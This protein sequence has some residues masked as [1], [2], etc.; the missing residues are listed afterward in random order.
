MIPL[1]ARETLLTVEVEGIDPAGDGAAYATVDGRRVRIDYAIA[2]ERVEVR[3]PA[4]RGG[5]IVGELARVLRPSPHRV[6]PGCPYFGP[7][8]GCTWQHI[9][10]HEQLRLKEQMLQALLHQSLGRA[11]PPVRPTRT[12]NGARSSGLA[13]AAD[14]QPPTANREP[15]PVGPDL[16]APWAFRNKVHFVLAPASRLGGLV[17]GHYHRRSQSVV[18]VDACPVHAGEGNRVAFAVRD[19][20]VRARVEGAP[21]D[22]RRGARARI[23][24]GAR[25]ACRRVARHIVVRATDTPRET[26]ATL[27]V[28]R[29]ERSLRP[30]V[31]AI[32]EAAAPDGLHLNVNDRP[33]PYLFG[34]ET[35]RLY[36]RE[37]VR[38]TIAG[39]SF[40]ISPTAFFQ[41][42]VR[43]AETMVQCVLENAGEPATALDLYA[44]AGLFALP[45]ATRG[46]RVTAVEE[47]AEAV[48]DGE[49]SRGFNRIAESRCRFVRARAED[50]AAG[51]GRRAVSGAPDLVVLDPPRVGCPANVLNWICTSLRPPRIIY[52]SCNPEALATD[53]QLPLAAG[54][55]LQ[56]VQ[57]VDMFPHTAHIETIAVLMKGE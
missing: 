18:E 44:G 48:E 41:T 14:G 19:A 54:Y 35:R 45:L 29:N 15:A 42:N 49:A 28:T 13:S 7:C 9:A 52:V 57:P 36:G 31:R 47:N 3:I 5:S 12:G 23:D 53:L 25:D 10:Y 50:V 40:L 4:H 24:R 20:L 33:G 6:T 51:R 16:I 1:M 55:A 26:L 56:L 11:A 17:I 34:P 38:E 32:V 30:A 46:V 39:V 2:G 27:V 37:R 43:A 8:G 21:L 22:V